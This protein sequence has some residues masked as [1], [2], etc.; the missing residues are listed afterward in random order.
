M[1][2]QLLWQVKMATE[3]KFLQ[4]ILIFCLNTSIL[5]PTKPNKIALCFFNQNCHTFRI[6]WIH[7]VC[8][9]RME[10]FQHVDFTQKF[11]LVRVE[12]RWPEI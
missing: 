6:L 3:I 2:W 8:N 7:C 9:F 12:I 11:A 4:I 5:F 1:L 10:H